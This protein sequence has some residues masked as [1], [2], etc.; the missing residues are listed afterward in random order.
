MA[1]I[2]KGWVRKGSVGEFDTHCFVFFFHS[3]PSFLSK[4]PIRSKWVKIDL[5]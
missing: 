1:V 5:N 3:S 2:E 4:N